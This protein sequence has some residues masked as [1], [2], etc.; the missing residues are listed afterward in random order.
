MGLTHLENRLFKAICFAV[1]L[2]GSGV[3]ARNHNGLMSQV[4]MIDLPDS[5]E[6]FEGC[7]FLDNTIDTTVEGLTERIVRPGE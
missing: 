5:K 1:R 4:N 3:V 2:T 6:W 7:P